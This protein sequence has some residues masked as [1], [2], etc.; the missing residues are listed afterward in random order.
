MPF[1]YRLSAD[2]QNLLPADSDFI[3]LILL[4]CFIKVSRNIALATCCPTASRFAC[5]LH[6]L[7]VSCLE[8]S[9]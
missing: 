5:Q 1:F 8:E 7:A 3:H 4:I 2:D 6:S 9:R